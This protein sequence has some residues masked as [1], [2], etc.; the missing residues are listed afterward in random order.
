MVINMFKKIEGEMGN[1]PR[2]LKYLKGN[3]KTKLTI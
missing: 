1:L 3:C 2:D